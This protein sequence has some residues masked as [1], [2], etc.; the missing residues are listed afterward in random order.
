MLIVKRKMTLPSINFSSARKDG[1]TYAKSWQNKVG[2]RK[3][4]IL[5]KVT[6]KGLCL[7]KNITE[8]DITGLDE[9]WQEE[10][11][12]LSDVTPESLDALDNRIQNMTCP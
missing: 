6:L 8:K 7:M 1:I 9:L 2:D 4:H 10:I 11:M 5:Y 3:R 12:N